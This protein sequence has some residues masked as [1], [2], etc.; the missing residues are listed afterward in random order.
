MNN[1]VVGISAE[2]AIA[3]VFGVYVSPKYRN[4]GDL[5]IKTV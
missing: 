3:D 5:A 2:L 4:R 1:E